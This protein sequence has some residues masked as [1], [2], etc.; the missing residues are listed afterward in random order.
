MKKILFIILSAFLVPAAF[1]QNVNEDINNRFKNRKQEGYFNTTQISMLMGNRPINENNQGYYNARTEFFPSVTMTNG[2][3]LDKHWA[4]GIGVG[5]EIF[6][7]NLFPVFADVRYTLRDNK[8]SPFFVFKMGNA[9]G[10]FKKKHYDNMY[11]NY[12]PYYVSNADFR[13]YG[14]FLL[15]PEMGVKI[16]LSENADLMFTVAYRYQKIKSKIIQNGITCSSY[17]GEEEYK[18]SFNRLSFGVAIM[19]R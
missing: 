18:S 7:R 13:N 6:D 12:E 11:F 8:V 5:F 10:N 9:F 4:A 2:Y 16:P 1:S 19:F 3:M 15:H 14:G 17:Y